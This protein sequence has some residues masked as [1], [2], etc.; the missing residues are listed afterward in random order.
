VPDAVQEH[1]PDSPPRDERQLVRVLRRF[2]ELGHDLIA[3]AGTVPEALAAG[4]S[5]DREERGEP[6]GCV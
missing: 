2:L 5:H 6:L 3:A 1:D 4:Q